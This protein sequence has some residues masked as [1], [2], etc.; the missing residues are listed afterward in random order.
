M[1][2]AI[3]D[4]GEVILAFGRQRSTGD[5]LGFIAG[6]DVASLYFESD[7]VVAEISLSKEDFEERISY[8]AFKP[9]LRSWQRAWASRN[10]PP[11]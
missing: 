1:I 10:H 9:I 6:V 2:E 4:P 3:G 11:T 5:T 7:C 8:D